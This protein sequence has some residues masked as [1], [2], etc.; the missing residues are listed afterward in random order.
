MRFL[1]IDDDYEDITIL[2]RLLT[3]LSRSNVVDSSLGYQPAK[4]M[5]KNNQYDLIFIDFFLTE[6][7]GDHVVQMIRENGFRMPI[8]CISDSFESSVEKLS[9]CSGATSF[10]LKRTIDE[11]TL[12]I[13]IANAMKAAQEAAS[14]T[15]Q[16]IQNVP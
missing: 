11:E 12:P 5:I 4:A 8:I 13:F 6:E 15:T 10:A 2:R 7:T 3:S 16:K 14:W 9:R 1:I